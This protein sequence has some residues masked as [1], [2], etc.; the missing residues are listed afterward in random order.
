MKIAARGGDTICSPCARDL[1]LLG[2]SLAAPALQRFLI[3]LAHYHGQTWNAAEPARSLGISETTV[4]RYLDPL[5]GA[6]LIRQ[7]P[8]WHANI[9]KR[10]KV[11]AGETAPNSSAQRMQPDKPRL[12]LHIRPAGQVG[13]VG[14]PVANQFRVPVGVLEFFGRR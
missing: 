3:M 14:Q 2:M 1:P 13:Q 5:T 7:L 12:A 9:A 4:R 11:G 8:P 10:P 6:Y